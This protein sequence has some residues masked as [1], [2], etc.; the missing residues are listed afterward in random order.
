MEKITFKTEDGKAYHLE[1]EKLNPN[2][3]SGGSPGRVRQIADY[4]DNAEVEEGKRGMTVV[5]GDYKGI[6]VS[7]FPTGMGPA[8]TSIIIPEV[9]ESAVDGPLT[10]LRLGTAGSLQSHVKVGDLAVITGSVRDE[11]TTSA[12]VGTEY[13]AIASPE[14]IPIILATAEKHGYELGENLWTGINHVKDDLYFKETPQFSPSREIME[15]R[16]KSYKRMGTVASSMEF[17]VYAIMRDFYEGRRS[18]KVLTGG[19]LAIIAAAEEEDA[20]EVDKKQKKKLV[21]GMIESGLDTLKVVNQFRNDEEINMNFSKII[22]KMIQ[23]PSRY[24]LQK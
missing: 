5:H 15:P 22:A 4:L 21:K 9:I 8:S 23:T 11:T 14:L 24:E 6:P 20:V 19:I 1:V 12:A 10:I 13:P 16:L 18:G 2:I 7:A 3:L 17:S